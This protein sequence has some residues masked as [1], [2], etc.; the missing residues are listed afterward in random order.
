MFDVGWTEIVVIACVAIIVVGPKDLPRVLRTVG[1]TVGNLKRMAGDFQK[2]FDDALKEADLDE[3]KKMANARIDLDKPKSTPAIEKKQDE[4]DFDLSWMDDAKP[5]DAAKS[6]ASKEVKAAEEL[7]SPASDAKPAK[8][9]DTA[10]APAK[11]SRSKAA[12]AAAGKSSASE[13]ARSGSKPSAAGKTA[14][15]TAGSTAKSKSVASG[16][17]PAA[18]RSTKKS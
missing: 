1:K 18:K 13:G 9:A 16:K 2:Q 11:S 10:K 12:S 5:S 4:E 7:P 3:V 6:V 17:T 8:K 15:R 14:S